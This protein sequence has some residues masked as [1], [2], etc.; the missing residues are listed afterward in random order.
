MVR[1]DAEEQHDGTKVLAAAHLALNQASEGSSPSG[2]TK[3]HD[4]LVVQWPRLRTRNAA[5]RV[6]VPPGALTSLIFD[7]S[8]R[9]FCTHDVA[10]ACCL[11][12]AEVRVR[13]P[14]GALD[15]QGVG[16]P[17]IPPASEAG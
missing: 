8:A 16:K 13:L 1:A 12:R 6:R 2:P 7:N 15:Q 17:G 9:L 5:T 14:L 3:Q 4:A 10:V 11:A